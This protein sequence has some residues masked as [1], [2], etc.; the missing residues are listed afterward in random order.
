MVDLDG[1]LIHTDL[2]HESAVGLLARSPVALLT[3][4]LR[5]RSERAGLKAAIAA[6]TDIDV[7][8]L[9]YNAP[10]LAWLQDQREMGRTLVLCTASNYRFAERVAEH[11]GIFDQVLASSDGENLKGQRK[12]DR[13]VELFGAEGYDY[14]GD[15]A[16]DLPVWQSAAEAVLVNTSPEVEA[17][18]RASGAVSAVFPYAKPQM[19]DWGELLR[20]RQWLKNLLIFAPLLAA[21]RVLDTDI[22][23]TIVLAFVAFSLSASAIY[24]VNDLFDLESDRRHPRKRL[25][26]VASGR[27][28]V[29]Q[30]VVAVPVLLFFSLMLAL[31]VSSA[32]VYCLAVY[33]ILT[34]L[35]SWRLKRLLIVDCLVLASLY[36]L[37]IIAGAAAIE[38]GLSFWLLAFSVFLFLSLA[39]VKRYAELE[40]QQQAGNNEVAGRGYVLSDAPIV[41]A[42]GIGAGYVAVLV[43]SLYLNSPEVLLLYHSVELV[44]GAVL[45]LLFWVS[46]MWM[47]AHRANMHDDPLVF[48]LRDRSSLI[49]GALFLLSIYLGTQEWV[50]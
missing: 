33:L 16:A 21:H 29:W 36:T 40:V 14:A 38:M 24:L 44:W 41:Q 19:A 15:S 34:S 3:T 46:W 28:P 10:L 9:P 48:A 2:L 27:I 18:V 8:L 37:R 47:Q 17:R 12:A 39:F 31:S 22:Y 1:T 7:S 20:V 26:A 30:A 13:L 32:F 45:V 50:W 25:R 43:F 11:L 35:Y 49:A 6:R 42:L 5:H 23:L 4:L